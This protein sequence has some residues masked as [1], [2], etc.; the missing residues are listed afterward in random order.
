[1]KIIVEPENKLSL[2]DIVT[3]DT[4]PHHAQW[5]DPAIIKRAEAYRTQ[6]RMEE[7]MKELQQEMNEL[8][9]KETNPRLYRVMQKI[10]EKKK[11][12]QTKI[13]K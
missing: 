12:F 3:R 4:T 11:K 9:L 10:K 5:F 2:N 1:M 8:K 7:Q 6:A 13:N